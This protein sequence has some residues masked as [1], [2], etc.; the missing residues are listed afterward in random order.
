MTRI[1]A[2]DSSSLANDKFEPIE[3]PTAGPTSYFFFPDFATK[4]ELP[5][6]SVERLVR[7]GIA[8]RKKR[9]SMLFVDGEGVGKRA[10]VERTS[11]I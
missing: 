10:Y 4:S 1:H 5:A 3:V 9:V 7:D 6:P 8:Q 2:T 11:M